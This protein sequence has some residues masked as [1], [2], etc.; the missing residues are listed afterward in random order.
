MTSKKLNLSDLQDALAHGKNLLTH[1][2]VLLGEAERGFTIGQTLQAL[3]SKA[4]QG[5]G[6]GIPFEALVWL[7]DKA[8]V[9]SLGSPQAVK[10]AVVHEQGRTYVVVVTFKRG[11]ALD[12]FC[13]DSLRFAKLACALV[14]AWR[15][16]GDAGEP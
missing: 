1:A 13:T 4:A 9:G 12:L 10:K 16:Y 2:N 5:D 6:V 3:A 14:L 8:L 7:L 15:D 11:P